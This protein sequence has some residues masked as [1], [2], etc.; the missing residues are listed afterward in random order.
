MSY[1]HVYVYVPRMRLLPRDDE[2]KE[3]YPLELE[4]PMVVTH[5]TGVSN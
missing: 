1:L 5:H 3:L 4:L 2:K